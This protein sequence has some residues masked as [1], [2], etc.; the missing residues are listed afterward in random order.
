[1]ADQGAGDLAVTPSFEGAKPT[2]FISCENALATRMVVIPRTLALPFQAV[3]F[4]MIVFKIF[5]REK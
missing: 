4:C 1:M 5:G 2:S 3:N